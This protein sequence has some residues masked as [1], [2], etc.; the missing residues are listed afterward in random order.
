MKIDI[1]IS[2]IRLTETHY[3][4]CGLKK[5]V[6]QNFAG[7]PLDSQVESCWFRSNSSVNQNPNEAD[8]HDRAFHVFGILASY[9]LSSMSRN[10]LNQTRIYSPLR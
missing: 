10:S 4:P 5:P 9:M 3:V 7:L 1:A 8:S 2:K 6:I